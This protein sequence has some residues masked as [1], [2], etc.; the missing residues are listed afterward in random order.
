MPNNVK[1]SYP[2][3][4]LRKRTPNSY[5]KVITIRINKRYFELIKEVCNELGIS[6]NFFF[7]WCAYRSAVCINKNKKEKTK[8]LNLM[9]N[10]KK[11]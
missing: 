6:P 7:G 3:F 8:C 2:N 5:S 1:I 10:K 4:K 11:Q 9:K